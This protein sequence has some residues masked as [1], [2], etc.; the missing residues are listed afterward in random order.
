MKGNSADPN[1][2][3]YG[4]I[5]N[6]LVNVREIQKAFGIKHEKVEPEVDGLTGDIEQKDGAIYGTDVVSNPPADIKSGIKR[7][8][9]ALNNNFHAFWNFQIVQDSLTLNIKVIDA[10]FNLY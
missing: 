4:R 1:N 7:L 2:L 8:L 3:S 9:S 6:I 5:R 10:H